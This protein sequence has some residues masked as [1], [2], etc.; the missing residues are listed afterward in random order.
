MQKYFVE[1][2]GYFIMLVVMFYLFL[3]FLVFSIRKESRKK[4]VFTLQSVLIFVMQLLCF[5]TIYFRL[6]NWEYLFFYAFVQVFLFAAMTF[7]QMLYEKVNRLL[8]NN[9]CMLLGISF[10]I[11]SRLSLQ[12][13]VKQLTITIL[14]FAIGLLV[15]VVIKKLK[16][17][18]ELTWGYCGLGILALLAVYV[19]GNI[20]HG[21]K[22]SF[23]IAD[24]TFQPSEFVK[25]LFV[26]FL[27]AAFIK[28]PNFG[29]VSLITVFA[30]LHVGILVLSK[31]LGSALIFFVAY[32][33]MLLL[34]TGNYL[35]FCLG[36]L[37]GTAGALGGYF[38][39]DHVRVRVLA[40][41][42]PFAFIDKQ[43]YQI[44]QSLFAIGSG[45]WFGMGLNNGAPADIPYVETDLIFSAV[46]EEMGVICG[47]CVLFICISSFIKMMQ[48][49]LREQER[50]YRLIAL[51]LGVIYIFQVFL[52]V[53]GGIKFIPLTGVTLPFISYGGSSVLT[54]ML[55]FFCVQ[56]V[57]M[58]QAEQ[59]NV[60]PKDEQLTKKE[61]RNVFFVMFTFILLFAVMTGYLIYFVL[62][63]EQSLIN[64]S[65]NSRQDMLM[66][67]NYRGPIYASGGEI[68]AESIL[69]EDGSETRVY[70]Y[71]GKFAHAVGFSTYGRTGVESQ[72]NYYLINSS[73]SLPEKVGNDVAGNKNPGDAVYTTFDVAV[74]EAAVKALDTYQGAII[75]TEPS[76]GRVL[77]MVSNPT[78]DPNEIAD[79]WDALTAD[80]ENSVLVNRATQGLYPPGSTFKIITA[81]E[82]IRENRDTW[83]EYSYHCTGHHT[84]DGNRINCYH[85]ID[86][87]TVDFETSFAK[88]CNS[89]F[90]NIGLLLDKEDFGKTLE[91]LLFGQKLPV[92]FNYAQS[93]VYLTEDIS[94][95]D[96]MQTSIGQGRTQ[97]T[98][99]H[100]NMITAAI[101]NNG[102]MMKPYVVD[103][104]ESADG[105]QVASFSPAIAGRVMSEEEAQILTELM[106]AVVEKGTATRLDGLSYTAAGKTGSAE[107]GNVKGESHAWFTGFAPAENP[108]ICVTIILEGAGSGG[109]YAVPMAKRIFNAWFDRE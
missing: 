52:T 11:L 65:Y 40:W 68:L 13:A 29:R 62:T 55:L 43:G 5:M 60:C 69:A 76:S 74:Q 17:W 105:K 73:V 81:L 10:V 83:M 4:A 32:V 89:S 85:G 80:K 14:S 54:T 37:A 36:M 58:R 100:L 77:A 67:Q 56:A 19:T 28:K 109:D 95:A 61:S 35:Y 16:F 2:S 75:V 24:I 20:T 103:Y 59:I 98:P 108:E 90:A 12:K 82:Y 71:G 92:K 44:T 93:S 26:F 84:A 21:S 1:L 97:M 31:D 25:L 99:L 101:G 88:S 70:P 34:A 50:F 48:I 107:Y 38:L 18:G 33:F 102:V 104:V 41:Y 46:C 53:G 47:I 6:G 51:G 23:S 106:A 86:H 96:M 57:F 30:A 15:P 22:L 27:A 63:N 3:A 91:T 66:A 94:T 78:F 87:G 49:G 64:N 7:P 42:N 72:A 45:N 39:F 8:L 9:M 79:I